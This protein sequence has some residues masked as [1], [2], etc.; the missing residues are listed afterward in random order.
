MLSIDEYIDILKNPN[1]TKVIA[2]PDCPI[3]I[4]KYKAIYIPSFDSTPECVRHSIDF[5]NL[6][7]NKIVAVK[8][9]IAAF[10]AFN[11]LLDKFSGIA[12]EELGS[13]NSTTCEWSQSSYAPWMFKSLGTGVV[14]LDAVRF[15]GDRFWFADNEQVLS[16]MQK[17]EKE[18][19]K[20]D[21]K[22]KRAR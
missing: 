5:F 17:I 18:L 15:D 4:E 7:N 2:Q 11:C 20:E 14:Y 22:D 6:S 1:P 13:G 16:E 9:G 8:F 3:K 12:I 19:T 21:L 10:D